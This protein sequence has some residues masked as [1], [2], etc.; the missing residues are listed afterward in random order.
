MGNGDEQV[1]TLNTEKKICLKVHKKEKKTKKKTIVYSK[2]S[3][4]RK[5]EEN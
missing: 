3:R 2:Q 4:N 1:V 5:E